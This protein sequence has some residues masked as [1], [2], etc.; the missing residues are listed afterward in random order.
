MINLFE[1]FESKPKWLFSIFMI[2]GHVFL[3]GLLFTIFIFSLFGREGIEVYNQFCT[4]IISFC[5][6]GAIKAS[7]YFLHF[8]FKML[9]PY[10]FQ[11]HSWS[12][13]SAIIKYSIIIVF[14]CPLWVLIRCDKSWI[15]SPYFLK[16]DVD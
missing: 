12:Q 16:K 1:L 4:I 15:F 2:S 9:E 13:I 11:L 7:V 10:K 5:F 3:C 8:L 14:F 6:I